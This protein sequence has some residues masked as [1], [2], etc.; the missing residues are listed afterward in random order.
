MSG[1]RRI[2]AERHAPHR[3][4][5]GSSRRNRSAGAESHR[6]VPYRTRP[7]P[8]LTGS[9]APSVFVQAGA[10]ATG[11]AAGHEVDGPAPS[12][13]RASRE[14]AVLDRAQDGG[15]EGS[16]MVRMGSENAGR[17]HPSFSVFGTNCGRS[18]ITHC[19]YWLNGGEGGI[20]TLDGG[21]AHTPLAGERLQPLGHLSSRSAESIPEP[22]RSAKRMRRCALPGPERCRG[23]RGPVSQI[24]AYPGYSADDEESSSEGEVPFSAWMRS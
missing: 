15:E 5:Q 22:L 8:D 12:K 14:R 4:H 13:P 16:P 6:R 24:T 19:F 17:R 9:P 20:R 18:S 11:S 21:L 23:T 1:R 10:R 7:R 3:P 2:G